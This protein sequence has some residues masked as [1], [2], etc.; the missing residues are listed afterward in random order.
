MKVKSGYKL[1]KPLFQELEIPEEWE[2]TKLQSIVDILDSQRIP[3]KESERAKRSGKFPYYGASGIIDYID[4]YIFDEKLLCLA[5]D[6]ENLVSRVLPIAFTL[7]DKTWVNNHAHVLRVKDSTDHDFIEFTLNHML[8]LKYVAFTA[9]PKLNQKDMSSILIILPKKPEQEK[10]SSILSSVDELISSIENSIDYTKKLKKGL[11]Q[12]LLNRGIDHKK[13]RKVKSLFGKY[14]ELP[15]EWDFRSFG[16]FS[17]IRRGASPRPIQDPKYFGNGR[18]WIR[19][20]DVSRSFK[21]LEKTKDYLSESGESESVAVNNGDVIMSIA[22]TVGRPIILNMKACIHDGFILF[23]ELSDEIHNEFLY[24]LLKYLESRF[25]NMG[26]QGSQSNINSDLVSKT[27]FKKPS[28]TEQR[29]IALILSKVDEKISD[30]QSK[31]DYLEK[32][33]KGLMQKLL[34]GQI[35]VNA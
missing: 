26:Q 23:S 20:S 24:Y 16:D 29:K 35:R 9:Q 22:A 8:L 27:K 30:L 12:K 5:E 18:G 4:D 6:G 14:E 11:M 34:T 13:F 1:V 21:Y 7:E 17:K 2:F 3:I 32:L 33:K 31:K 28:L 25:L 10:I 15:E 19:I